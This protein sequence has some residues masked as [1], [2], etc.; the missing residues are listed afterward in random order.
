MKL[1]IV[2]DEVKIAQALKRGLEEQGYQIDLAHDGFEGSQKFEMNIY[3]LI[4]I[5][6]NLP[7]RNGYDLCKI[8][9]AKNNL[10]P[11]IMLTAFNTLESKIKGF[12]DGADDYISKPFEFKELVVRIRSLLKRVNKLN[13]REVEIL[14]IYNLE[15][16]MYNK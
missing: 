8:I 15:M 2:E 7:K 14:K 1:L 9:R 16:N 5:D 10:I 3:D 13:V 12:D 6:I 4:L 11:I